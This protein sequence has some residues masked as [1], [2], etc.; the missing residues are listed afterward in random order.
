[1]KNSYPEFK[2]IRAEHYKNDAVTLA[3]VVLLPDASEV[4]S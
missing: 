3:L 4:F 1:M 2:N